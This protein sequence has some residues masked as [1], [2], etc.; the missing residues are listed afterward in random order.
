MPSLVS[1]L[2]AG[3]SVVDRAASLSYTLSKTY[4]ASNFLDE[5]EFQTV[6][7]LVTGLGQTVLYPEA[8]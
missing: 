6:R 5:F 1:W 2:V 8:K 3:L 4:D 7:E